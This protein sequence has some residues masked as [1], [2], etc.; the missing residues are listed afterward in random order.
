MGRN[1]KKIK[2]R[3]LAGFMELPPEKQIVFNRMK[4]KI[5]KVFELNGLSPMDTP[6]LEY[7][8]VLLAKAGGETEKQIYR[9]KKGDADICMR[10]DL[11]VP[12]AKYIAIFQNNL[13]FPFRRYQVGKSFRG[14]RTQ[15]GRFREF[16]QCDMD[17]IDECNYSNLIAISNDMTQRNNNS[18]KNK[19]NSD[20]AQKDISLND[21]NVDKNRNLNNKNSE[22]QNV[23]NNNIPLKNDNY[24]NNR[25]VPNEDNKTIL[26]CEDS[27]RSEKNNKGS[28]LTFL[29]S[30][31]ECIDV[32]SQIYSALEQSVI[33][34]VSNRK[35]LSGVLDFYGLNEKKTEIF[36]LLDKK[37]KI[38]ET[39]FLSQL[40]TLT[41][42]ASEILKILN[43][44][45]VSDLCNIEIQNEIFKQGVLEIRQLFEILKMRKLQN[46]IIFDISIIRGLDYYTGTVFETFL[47]N[48]PE[49][50][51]VGGGGRYDNLSDCFTHRKFSG[52]GMSVGLTRLF[53]L[54]DKNNLLSFTETTTTHVAIVPLTNS[55]KNISIENETLN[56]EIISHCI[57]LSA[58]LIENKI[59]TEVL[60][61]DKP[62][63][64]KLNYANK[65]QIPYI[66]VVGENEFI[67]QKYSLKN[68]TTGESVFC[69]KLELI[70]TLS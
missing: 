35:I 30:D 26:N 34:K 66:I 11:T 32:L 61:F 27:S 51:S 69:N 42:Y 53:D 12:F 40:N 17:I 36:T 60:Y 1:M 23:D 21:E 29:H 25:A 28:L 13:T 37:N 65:K 39:D 22:N 33:I 57:E 67:S 68:M 64:N 45:C 59:S 62:F 14:E 31:A 43:C 55:Q 4:D 44:G 50:I 19:Q 7:S 15:K 9:F 10:F 38:N 5:A 70:E 6:I 16:Y 52:V 48:L 46:E 49:K 3:T 56:K 54:L 47:Q 2:A 18:E 20:T 58:F 24:N 63:K 8:D 41:I